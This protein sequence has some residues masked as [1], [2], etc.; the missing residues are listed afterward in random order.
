MSLRTLFR[1]SGEY[2]RCTMNGYMTI[3]SWQLVLNSRLLQVL[4][5]F[6]KQIAW[7]EQCIKTNGFIIPLYA[8]WA[9]Y[10]IRK[11]AGCACAGNAGNVFPA[12][13]FKGNRDLGMHR[14]T[15]V[16]QVPWC[17]SGLLTCGGGENVPGIPSA[18][19]TRTQSQ[20]CYYVI[21]N[22]AAISLLQRLLK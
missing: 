9:S 8:S 14:G 19:A 21:C 13:D 7:D 18:C 5:M 4:L 15:C 12:T 16:T 10:Q 11:I 20:P 3:I 2:S 17:V 6:C 1:E 22:Y